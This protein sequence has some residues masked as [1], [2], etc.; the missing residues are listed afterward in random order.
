MHTNLTRDLLTAGL[1]ARSLA[2]APP[3]KSPSDSISLKVADGSVSA[4]PGAAAGP[5]AAHKITSL[6]R[7]L[8][9]RKKGDMGR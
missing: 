2:A 8:A 7:N 5:P 4:E 9:G 1:L 6:S 3:R